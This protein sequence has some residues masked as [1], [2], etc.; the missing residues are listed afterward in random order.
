MHPLYSDMFAMTRQVGAKRSVGHGNTDLTLAD[1]PA[2][3]LQLVEE[4][5]PGL[6]ADHVYL[7]VAGD[8][9]ARLIPSHGNTYG[10]EAD[11]GH[12]AYL[13]GQPVRTETQHC[14]LERCW[15]GYVWVKTVAE[16][17]RVSYKHYYAATEGRSHPATT[18]Y[19]GRDGANVILQAEPHY[20]QRGVDLRARVLAAEAR[21]RELEARLSEPEPVAAPAPVR[22]PD[23][24]ALAELPRGTRICYDQPRKGKAVHAI[25]QG[26]TVEGSDGVSYQS[27]ST[28]LKNALGYQAAN[29]WDGTYVMQGDKKVMLSAIRA[30]AGGGGG[31]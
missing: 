9:R 29:G 26:E 2:A 15:Y 16:D 21:I 17:D 11:L 13:P 25:Y 3:P 7:H 8:R 28:W 6:P 20:W 4:A 1:I 18:L 23:L 14:N 24:K 12:N 19:M 27:L 22:N 31:K 10:K 30:A 5:V